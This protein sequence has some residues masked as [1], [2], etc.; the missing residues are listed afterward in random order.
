M[1]DR[2]HF[3]MPRILHALWCLRRGF[4]LKLGKAPI[5]GAIL[6]VVRIVAFGAGQVSG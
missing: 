6:D 1:R 3:L 5:A 4:R 2:M